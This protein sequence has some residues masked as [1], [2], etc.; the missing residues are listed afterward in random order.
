MPESFS[1]TAELRGGNA[2]TLIGGLAYSLRLAIAG[3]PNCGKTTVFNALTGAHQHVGNYSGVTV[4]KKEGFIRHEGQEIILVDLPGAYSLSAYSQEEVVARNVLLGGA[5][6]AVINV[7]DAGILERGLLLTA[8]L[9]EMGLPV[10]IACNM[11]DEARAAGI[12]IDFLR[13]S[14]LMGASALPTVGTAGNGL[15]EALSAARQAALDAPANGATT[16]GAD[17]APPFGGGQA[18]RISYG[19]LLDPILETMEHRIAASPGLA[20]SPYGHCAPRWLALNLLQDDAEAIAALQKADADLAADMAQ[21]RRFVQDELRSIGRDTEGIIADGHSCFVRQVAAACI[22]KTGDRHRLSLSDRLDRV[23]A[24]AVWGALIMLGVLYAMFQI[25]IVLG[26]YPQGWLE[27][28]FSALAGQ[29]RGALP[30][31]LF[32]SLLVD[33][34]I[35]GVGGVLSFV[36]LVLIM[37]ALIAIVEDSG[38]MARMAYIADRVFQ[39]FGLHGASVMPYIISG[40][41]A[42]GCAIPGVMA[43]RTMRSPK[44]KLATMLTLPY[45]ACGAKL[46]VYLLLVG[47]FF[48]R[49]AANMMF[50]V[51]MLSWVLAF[52]VAL[53]LRKTVLRGEATPLVMEMPPYRMPTLRGICIHCWERTWMY[54]KKAGTV[55]VPLAMLIW[56]AMTFPALDPETALPYENEI[57][58][59]SARIEREDISDQSRDLYENSRA[60]VQEEL[61][62]ERLRRTLAG[63]LGTWLEGV[64]VYAGFSWRTDVALIGGIA[65]K[66]AIISTLGTAYALGAQDPED[67]AS[68]AELLRSDPSWNQGTALALLIF[69]MLYAPC[70]VTLVVIRQESGSWK[71][72]AFSIAFNTLLAFGMAVGVYQTYRFLGMGL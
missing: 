65:A 32:A 12:S 72:V 54:L 53:L 7:V 30:D 16:Q 58:R 49:N 14:E 69:V 41:I 23:L 34:V 47:T 33:G 48:P 27:G 67:P 70:F 6:Q 60:K 68:L 22:V 50:A 59:L 71:W 56:A 52:C 46:P 51:I 26:S 11:M 62:A 15:R 64:T 13:L 3:N 42:G 39:F 8:Q 45:M 35:A 20:A 17:D 25:T 28:A 24:H 5:V 29:V 37:F 36:P 66:E 10:V 2:R 38:Y 18:L 4:E 31:G 61:E 19:P 21:V 40:G 63:S 9:R 1:E 55:L 44:E 43:T 57:A